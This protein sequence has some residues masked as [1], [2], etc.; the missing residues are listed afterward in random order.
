[1]DQI[2]RRRALGVTGAL[3]AGAVSIPV[4]AAAQSATPVGTPV[5]RDIAVT[6]VIDLTHLMTPETPVWSGNESFSHEVVRMY[7]TD[8]FYAQALRFWEHTGTHLDAPAHFIEGADTAEF[9]PVSN[10]L[11]PLVV[12]DIS[13]R[14]VDDPDIAVMLADVEAWE[15]EHGVIPAGAFVAMNSGWQQYIDMPEMFVN[16]DTD[17]VMHFPG[18]HP[19]AATFLV[20]QRTIVGVGTDTLSL[21]PGN[22]TD[23]G[24]HIA[25]LGAGK[26]GIEG[27]AALDQVPVIGATIVVGAPKHSDASGGPARVLALVSS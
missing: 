24:T 8:G 5:V 9:L 2:S 19:E 4:M 15:A 14:A 17:G 11:A 23:F 16:Q 6:S 21:D 7:D 27:L 1:M 18:F 3:V 10:F 12:I 13:A 22:S 25:V 20:E 26:Y